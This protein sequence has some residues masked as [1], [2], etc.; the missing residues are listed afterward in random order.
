[1]WLVWFLL[2]QAKCCFRFI[3][4]PFG[5]IE[6]TASVTTFFVRISN[7]EPTSFDQTWNTPNGY[8]PFKHLLA[9][10]IKEL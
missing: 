9:A 7:H 4:I 6:T 8:G 5:L 10:Q 3:S 1:V 2:L